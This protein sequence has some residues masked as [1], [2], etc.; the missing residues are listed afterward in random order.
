MPVVVGN[1]GKLELKRERPDPV[2]VAFTGQEA[3][4]QAAQLGPSTLWPGDK[5]SLFSENGLPFFNSSGVPLCPG[6]MGMIPGTT[7]H[8]HPS[9]TNNTTFFPAALPTS[10]WPSLPI[11]TS[12]EVHVGVDQL[13]RVSFYSSRAAGVNG[14][15]ANRIPIAAV[16]FGTLT[17]TPFECDWLSVC[18]LSRW[19]LNTEAASVDQ[20]G[21][22]ARFGESLKTLLTGGGDLDYFVNRRIKS[23]TADPT[24]LLNLLLMF[25]RGC[26]AEARF[27]MIEDR[28]TNANVELL[29]GDLYYEAK[30]LVVGTSVQTAV[31]E[32]ISGSARFITTGP[33]RLKVGVD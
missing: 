3:A 31:A 29:P 9:W 17:I 22:G 1:G 8:R 7:L 33:I 20:T 26:V 23:G 4:V 15:L 18:N 16:N 28:P 14:D 10:F 5:V 32:L 30:L 12:A 13:N 19:T 24:M 6:G 25:E 11:Q 21:L 27:W 2:A